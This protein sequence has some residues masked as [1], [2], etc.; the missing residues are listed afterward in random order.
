M[1]KRIILL[2]D[3]TGNAAAKVWRTNVW[4]TFEALDLTKPDQIAIYDDGVG[5]STFKPA[6][7]LGGAFGFGLKRNVLSLYKFLCRNYRSRDDY[8]I[9]GIASGDDEIFAFGFSRGAFTIR[10]LIGFVLDQGLVKY[11]TED[12]LNAKARAAYRAHREKEYKTN[13]G[14]EVPFRMLRNLFVPPFH[15]ATERPVA[16]IRFL[17]LWDTVAAYG[18]PVDEMTYG[19]S[20]YVW[21]LEFADRRLSPQVERACHALSLDDERTTFHPVLWDESNIP[22]P[23]TAGTRLTK[24]EKISQVWFAGVH[25]NVGGG[26]PDNSLAHMSLNWILKE[27]SDCGLRFKTAPTADPDALVALKSRQDPDGRLYDSRSGLAG[28]YRYGP[29]NV[30]DLSDFH[31]SSDQRDRVSIATPKIHESVF[32]RLKVNAHIYAPISLPERYEIVTTPTAASPDPAIVSP[33]SLSYEK[34]GQALTRYQH[35]ENIVWSFVWRRRVVYFLTVIASLHLALYPLIS[36]V[37]DSAEL[38]TRLRPLSDLIRL[39]ATVLPSGLERWVKVYA[40]DPAWFLISAA[41][42]VGLM[43][44]SSQIRVRLTDEMRAN[45]KTS[46]N[47]LPHTP[48]A[49]GTLSPYQFSKLQKAVFTILLVIVAYPLISQFAPGLT[50]LLW[51]PLRRLLERIADG[52]T[53]FLVVAT[54]I[55]L[56]LPTTWVA[57]FRTNPGYKRTIQS[58]KRTWFPALFAIMLPLIGLGLISHYVFSFRDSFGS[59]CT[60]SAIGGK[61]IGVANGGLAICTAANRAD[62]PRIAIDGTRPPACQSSRC[63][64]KV[65]AFDTQSICTASGI[66]LEK[67]AR[68][69]IAVKQD[70]PWTFARTPSTTRGMPLSAFEP[71]PNSDTMT[72]I[73]SY[74]IKALMAAMLPLKRT[75]D[76]PWGHVI[77]RYGSTGNEE[78]FLDPGEER[79]TDQREEIFQ[80]KRDGELFVY[81]NQPVLGV[82]PGALTF[83]NTGKAT[84]TVTRIPRR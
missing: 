57:G 68:Y 62:C 23:S 19:I 67:N 38:E 55:A 76:R 25:A 31:L 22:A 37:P 9:Q 32:T 34:S 7:I 61:P 28:Y 49:R 17:G 41:M 8:A 15:D 35:Q 11:D 73:R 33:D 2:S 82:W 44:V 78:S 45:W 51:T 20:R 84:V 56:L 59:V 74:A 81:L 29:R 4:R 5:T 66:Y 54:L 58:L 48:S 47:A 46:L 30:A 60:N 39:I 71:P 65:F 63:T 83:L 53:W 42:V 70:G 21:P 40:G 79:G 26:Y 3:G 16:K 80:P 12:Q 50:N 64:G 43:W 36:K 69:H 77:V 75:Y 6:A 14:T 18:L 13:I 72:V 24:H 1:S 27:A 10:V 52:L